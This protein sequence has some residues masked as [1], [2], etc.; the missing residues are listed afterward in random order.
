MPQ[1]NLSDL[2][3]LAVGLVLGLAAMYWVSRR[4]VTTKAEAM[5]LL[6]AEYL[7]VANMPGAA[8]AKA[9]ADEQAQDEAAAAKKLADIVSK[10]SGASIA[11]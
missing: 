4:P 9:L 5:K 2:V 11:V 8:E 10:V 6:A 3:W 1:V 7:I